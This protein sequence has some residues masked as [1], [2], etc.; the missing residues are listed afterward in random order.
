MTPSSINQNL[1]HFIGIYGSGMKPL[2]QMAQLMG[3][4][5]QGSD[6]SQSN[7]QNDLTNV[8]NNQKPM[9][10]FPAGT[11]VYS[12]AI[13]PENLELQSAY[14][15]ASLGVK[16]LHRSEFLNKI[17]SNHKQI[18]VTGTHGK[19]TTSSLITHMLDDL[20]Q[21]PL[22][23]IGAVMTRYSESFRYGKGDYFVA[24]ADESDGS[25]L[26]YHP[27]IA[28]I[29]NIDL[30]HME[31]YK[32]Y[33]NL[34][35]YFSKFID[36]VSPNGSTILYWD[37]EWARNLVKMKPNKC[38]LSF[39]LGLGCDVRAVDIRFQGFKTC[40]MAIVERDHIPVEIPLIGTHNVLNAL[41]ALALAR[42]LGLN[43][44]KSSESLKT[45]EGVYRRLNKIFQ[46]S[47]AKIFDDYAHNPGKITA[48]ISSL[49]AAFEND[50]LIVIFQP[51]RFS[52]L[53]TMYKEMLSSFRWADLVIVTPVYSAGE[54]DSGQYSPE[55]I[56]RD[57]AFH[58]KTNAIGTPSLL[59]AVPLI[60]ASNLRN[61]TILTLGA[62]D[63]RSITNKIQT[64]FND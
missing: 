55:K 33:E 44:Q 19:S 30:D 5:V 12:S 11:V 15:S 9:G 38:F 57:L 64:L 6:L 42:T 22:A 34:V 1:V 4:E 2:A 3:Y 46:N 26:T 29:T 54:V 35:S 7:D 63:V 37:Q 13:S 61:P 53:E 52:R 58:S 25:F 27:E 56:A 16:V 36:M 10:W 21:D 62:G 14:Q 28:V 20:S 40:F 31:F 48:C 41:A 8:S 50:P 45:F 39:G 18:L 51:H 17:M 23:A 24:E 49:K 47:K 59:G 43:L 60:Q 32:T